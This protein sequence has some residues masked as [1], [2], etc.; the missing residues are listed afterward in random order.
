M[1]KFVFNK[2]IEYVK[3]SANN[4][5]PE[6]PNA[7]QEEYNRLE[8]EA[9]KTRKKRE[10]KRKQTDDFN[11][12]PFAILMGD[13][14]YDPDTNPTA[15][16]PSWEF[17]HHEIP[18]YSG[19]NNRGADYT[20][21]LKQTLLSSG[22]YRTVR[23]PKS[24]Y[25]NSEHADFLLD[26]APTG[27]LGFRRV[28]PGENI[29]SATSKLLR[30]NEQGEKSKA[31]GAGT[32]SDGLD[33]DSVANIIA[34]HKGDAIHHLMS[35]ALSASPYK[36]GDDLCVCG[37]DSTHGCVVPHGRGDTPEQLPQR[38]QGGS[39]PGYKERLSQN[40]LLK[41]FRNVN[42]KTTLAH[43]F[44]EGGPEGTFMPM[45]HFT[46]EGDTVRRYTSYNAAKASD[47]T[48]DD[49][50]MY[51]R[52]LCACGDGKVNAYQNENI[53]GDRDCFK[54][55]V[56]KKESVDSNGKPILVPHT[57]GLGAGKLKYVNPEDAPTCRTCA[58]NKFTDDG[59]KSVR[60]A[61][62]KG[63]GHDLSAIDCDNC[64]SHD[65][66][67][68]LTPDNVCPYCDG[69]MYDKTSDTPTLVKKDSTSWDDNYE[70]ATKNHTADVLYGM[71][72]VAFPLKGTGVGSTGID[73]YHHE[74]R[75]DCIN[76]DHD[77]QEMF[78]ENGK[79]TGLPCPCH[80]R[81][82]ADSSTL[83]PGTHIFHG[84]SKTGA[85]AGVYVPTRMLQ[86]SMV[87]TYGEGLEASP[88][89][90]HHFPDLIDAKTKKTTTDFYRNMNDADVDDIN[91]TKPLRSQFVTGMLQNGVST[92][93]EDLLDALRKS[94]E[95]WKKPNAHYTAPSADLALAKEL[96][97]KVGTVPDLVH[98]Y[99]A[100][101]V[102]ERAVNQPVFR[103]DPENFPEHM[104]EGVYAVERTMGILPDANSGRYNM[105]TDA[106]YKSLRQGDTEGAAKSSAK[107]HERIKRFSGPR[108]AELFK[109][110]VSKFPDYQTDSWTIKPAEVEAKANE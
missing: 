96:A 14:D 36:K 66:S 94:E 58:G 17:V 35:L 42:G 46:T 3:T 49:P 83:P 4:F 6:L 19:E 7:K 93:K 82:A 65:S 76:C 97:S 22:Q 73:H 12:A 100:K 9:R 64:E 33:P 61:T 39:V 75:K 50:D 8:N 88:H 43:A 90:F 106:L 26:K 28:N 62:C 110:S 89:E 1:K 40:P 74:R 2:E 56:R 105:D 104:Q 5:E 109:Q 84:D 44:D 27:I 63:T 92:P 85:G 60:C 103:H 25:S 59:A 86:K 38:V 21:D 16:P 101:K 41:F 70:S 67:I 31:Q 99:V 52:P 13:H 45:T 87:D 29:S 10:K 51:E 91:S 81:S 47:V 98:P 68:H 53:V 15:E 108:S 34:N 23:I 20:R 95:N 77:D 57:I 37:G 30:A 11:D 24:Q 78:D 32:G 71:A 107:L 80:I 69:T 72:Q 79:A 54:G 48:G 18:K 55:N 102:K